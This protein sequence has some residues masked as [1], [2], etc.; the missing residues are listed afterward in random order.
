MV[1]RASTNRVTASNPLQCALFHDNILDAIGAAVNAAGGNKVVAGRLWP[2]LG[3]DVASARL[4]SA[5]NP[6]HAQKLDP[7]ELLLIARLARDVGDHSIAQFYARELGYELA[8]LDPEQAA[9]RAR[10]ARRLALLAELERLE[11]DE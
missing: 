7:S 6:D 1:T 10:K 3:T 8:P 2:S 5:L 4:R 9:K 11:E